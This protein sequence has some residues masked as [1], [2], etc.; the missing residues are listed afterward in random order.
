MKYNCEHCKYKT[1]IR[2]N[3]YLHKNG[4]KHK[5]RELRARDNQNKIDQSNNINIIN[6]NV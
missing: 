1:E 6:I 3:W 5:E 4:K 2:Q